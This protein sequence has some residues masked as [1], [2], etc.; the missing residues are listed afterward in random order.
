MMEGLLEKQ[1]LIQRALDAGQA[2]SYQVGGNHYKNMPIAPWDVMAT[3]LTPEEY[4][5][6]LKGNVIKYAMRSAQG[7]KEGAERDAA[8]GRHYMQKLAELQ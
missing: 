8:K 6:F 4:R 3:A 1:R 2:D 7:A 5:G